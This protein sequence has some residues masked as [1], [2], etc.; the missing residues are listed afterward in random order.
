M[1]WRLIGESVQV[2]VLGGRVVVRHAG[3]VVADHPLCA[4]R[5]Q[6]IVDRSHLAGVVGGPAAN[7]PSLAGLPPPL[8]DLLRP[9]AEYEVV[10]GGAW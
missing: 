4:G 6:R 5:R 10:A 9:L 7:G 1:P 8:P 3:Q 2:V